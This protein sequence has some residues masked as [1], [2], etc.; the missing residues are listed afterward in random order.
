M[1]VF[2]S[3]F[4]IVMMET[5]ALSLPLLQKLKKIIMAQKTIM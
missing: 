5:N 2:T 4:Q 3:K 1:N